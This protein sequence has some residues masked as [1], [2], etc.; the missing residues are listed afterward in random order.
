MKLKNGIMLLLAA[1]IWGTAFVAQTV[2][3]DYVGPFTFNG[4]RCFIGAFTLA[5]VCLIME[6]IKKNKGGALAEEKSEAEKKLQRKHL[7]QGGICC[8]LILFIASSLQQ[9]GLVYTAPGKAGFITACYIVLV[10]IIGLFL[11]RKTG[12]L[13]WVAV[14]LAVAGLYFLCIT[15]ALTINRGDIYVLLCALMFSFHIIAVDHFSPLVDGVKLSCSQFLVTGI[16]SLPFI[17]GME[18]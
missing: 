18:T 3:M 1:F 2:G 12:W 7:I 9:V 15:E 17:F 4:V 16:L 5:I 6:L 13:I 11:K 8:G 10:P 14:V